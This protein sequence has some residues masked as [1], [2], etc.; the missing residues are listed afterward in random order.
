MNNLASNDYWNNYYST[1]EPHVLPKSHVIRSWI[2][3]HIPPVNRGDKTCIEIGCYPGRYLTLFGDLGYELSGIDLAT[4]LCDL[5]AWFSKNGYNIGEFCN[6]DFIQFNPLKTFDVVSSFGFIEHFTT[7]RDVLIKQC[8]LV[9][10]DGFLIV[11]VPNFIGLFQNWFHSNFDEE[12]YNRHVISSMDIEKWTEIV[13]SKNFD[14]VY[15][16]YF[17]SF[18]FWTESEPESSLDK[19]LLKC[20]FR[21][22]KPLSTILPKDKKMYSPY[23]GLI[24]K[25]RNL[26]LG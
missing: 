13:K 15:K 14:I 9:K 18:G 7:W 4:K 2:N 5:P 10:E 25:K 26:A 12:N 20:L 21:L 16:G 11:E 19:L 22:R 3:Q 6:E 23:G 17:G 24:A 1:I 8:D